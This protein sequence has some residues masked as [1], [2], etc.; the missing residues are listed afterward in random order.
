MGEKYCLV[1]SGVKFGP[2][3]PLRLRTNWVA[4]EDEAGPAAKELAPAVGLEP[5]TKSPPPTTLPVSVGE[6]PEGA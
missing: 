6:E 1:R 4:A 3:R 5:T 2:E